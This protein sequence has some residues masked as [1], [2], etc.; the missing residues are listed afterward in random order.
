MPQ[1]TEWHDHQ[2]KCELLLGPQNSN[3][4]TT[5][6]FLGL[7]PVASFLLSKMVPLCVSMQMLFFSLCSLLS[8]NQNKNVSPPP[9][10][11]AHSGVA[12]WDED[13]MCLIEGG[14]DFASH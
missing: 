13:T 4:N 11:S 3:Y 2:L 14:I 7:V 1:K 12:S 8:C 10:S 6:I 9:H 5:E